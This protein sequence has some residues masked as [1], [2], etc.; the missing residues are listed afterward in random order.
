MAETLTK[1]D[2][3]RA[4][5]E[6]ETGRSPEEGATS[7]GGVRL[8]PLATERPDSRGVWPAERGPAEAP[9]T[10]AVPLEDA[11][12]KV[13]GADLELD[14]GTPAVVVARLVERGLAG[15]A[16]EP[17]RFRV[18][19]STDSLLTV[20]TI[21]ALRAVWAKALVARS[22]AVVTPHVQ[23]TTPEASI[24]R[25]D[26]WNNILRATSHAF[27]AIVAGA[28]GVTLAPFDA[29]LDSKEPGAERLA[30][31]TPELL[32]EECALADVVDPAGGSFALEQ[33]TDRIAR[34]AWADLDLGPAWD[35]VDVPSPV[36]PAP[37]AKET[38]EGIARRRRYVAADLQD[39]AVD[40]WPGQPRYARGPYA[41]MYVGRPWTVRQYS[42]FSTAEESN[43]FYRRNLAAGQRGLSIAF[44]LATHRG[45]DSDHPRVVGDVGM[46]GVAIDSIRDMEIL[47]DG[48]PLGEMSVSMTM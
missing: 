46:A 18:P 37:A 10:A 17:P 33:W 15:S 28:D 11:A 8:E 36:L 3:W 12:G 22:R 25:E 2:S 48:I 29:A 9:R 44:D 34:A 14:P 45:Y 35:D 20:V 47:F 41:S 19:A 21:R 26:P 39:V 42:G 40:A 5:F 30:A 23:V 13:I 4:R 1:A 38:P 32:T 31:L 7:F 24:T 43:A 27:A 16:N 6:K